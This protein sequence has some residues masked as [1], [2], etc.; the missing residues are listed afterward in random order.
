MQPIKRS[1]SASP[2]LRRSS[3]TREYCGTSG[4]YKPKSDGLQ[5]S[6]S[7]AFVNDFNCS[8]EEVLGSNTTPDLPFDYLLSHHP[9][10]E[11]TVSP[12]DISYPVRS[13][14][15]FQYMGFNPAE[16]AHSQI[17]SANTDAEQKANSA[18]FEHGVAQ[19]YITDTKPLI[20]RDDNEYSFDF[21]VPDHATF[22]RGPQ[23]TTKIANE[24]KSA[25]DLDLD[26]WAPAFVEPVPNNFLNTALQQDLSASTHM[27]EDYS[28]ASGD[29]FPTFNPSFRTDPLSVKH[30]QKS[31]GSASCS[32]NATT[33]MSSAL[34]LLQTLHIPPRTCLWACDKAS[35]PSSRQP[36][37]ID[38]VLATNK[39]I[40]RLVSDMLKCNCSSSFQMLLVLTI[41]CAKVM[42]W[43]RAM[44][45]NDNQTGDPSVVL[46]NID[47]IDTDEDQ[48][49]RILHQPITVG[50]YSLGSTLEN[51]IRTQVVFS[52]LQQLETLVE[53]LSNRMQGAN[54]GVVSS[55]IKRA[56][57]GADPGPPRQDAD[58]IRRSL[59][60]FLR[61]QLQAAKGTCYFNG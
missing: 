23:L 10:G 30:P 33:C 4:V 51:N 61:N 5:S 13:H 28:T 21:E 42:A 35:I 15:E 27:G 45:R 31:T 48:T 38:S 8:R 47:K 53:A 20:F 50:C 41:I 55:C 6:S 26:L 43:Y 39:D 29:Y 60:A 24:C 17:V 12:L 36:R 46:S 18:Y 22:D 16:K 9:R 58:T 3:K 56:A 32:E 57:W 14:S 52:E 59:S 1:P 7:G 2:T 54:F 40:V 44:I 49:E 11:D 37:M 19:Q 25:F 34:R